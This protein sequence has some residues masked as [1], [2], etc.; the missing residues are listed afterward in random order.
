ME[1]IS[2]HA[3]ATFSAKTIEGDYKAGRSIALGYSHWMEEGSTSREQKLSH[4]TYLNRNSLLDQTI[5]G[6]IL[7]EGM[8]MDTLTSEKRKEERSKARY[9]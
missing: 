1:I 3:Q 9:H 6:E 8:D 2:S 4:Q 5:R 7:K